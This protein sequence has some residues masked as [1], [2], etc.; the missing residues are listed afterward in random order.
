MKAHVAV[1]A[2]LAVM[3]SSPSPAEASAAPSTFEVFV[4]PAAG[5]GAVYSFIGSA[6][7][8]LDMAMYELEDPSAEAGLAA[9]AARGVDVRVLLDSAYAGAGAN[10]DAAAALSK[11]GV[12]VRWAPSS[13]IVHQK[14]VV[15]DSSAALVMTANLT[16]EYYST[17][18]DFLVEDRQPADVATIVRAFDDDWSG[19][20]AGSPGQV[21]VRGQQGDLVF[22]PGSE[23]A[24]VGLIG[25]ASSSVETSNEEMGSAAVEDAL[26]ADARRGVDVEVLMTADSSWDSAF[27]QLWAAGVHVRLCPDSSSALY[28]HAK[29]I[30]VDGTKTY[31]GSINYSTSSMVYNRELGLI[32]TSPAV[33]G[34]VAQAFAKWWA[35]APEVGPPA[36][37]SGPTTTS[38]P[39]ASSGT[40][41]D[42][43]PSG[44]YYRPGEYCPGK[45]LGKTITGP[46][47]TMTCEGP[48]GGSQPRWTST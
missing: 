5:F 4:E 44:H 14:T 42:K 47:G 19:D 30:V 38:P 41:P 31:V 45:D 40:V 9:D 17:S 6:K 11:V 1:G 3:L 36:G 20:L 2:T 26:E 32:T 46:S 21:P 23:G 18:A 34:P 48:P 12:H 13:V 35:A 16:S 39:G 27:K 15:V 8:S 10:K 25:S 28:I 33:T 37:A 29:A 7:H 22:S 43:S 24:L